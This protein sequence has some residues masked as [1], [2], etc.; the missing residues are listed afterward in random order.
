[1]MADNIQKDALGQVTLF[2]GIGGEELLSSLPVGHSMSMGY[3]MEK[4]VSVDVVNE[5]LEA[6]ECASGS[7]DY[8]YHGELLTVDQQRAT[9]LYEKHKHLRKG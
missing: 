4:F 2:K 8:D 3:R 1:M 7:F 6:L 5:L 9:Y